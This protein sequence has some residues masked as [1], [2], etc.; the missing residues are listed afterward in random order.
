MIAVMPSVVVLYYFQLTLIGT[1]SLINLIP[2][3]SIYSPILFAISWSNPLKRMDLTITVT[4][5]PRPARNP[6]HS[7]AT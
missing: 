6:A 4:S 7:K 2:C 1:N 3:S 5:N